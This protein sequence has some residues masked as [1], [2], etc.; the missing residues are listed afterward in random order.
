M[1]SIT[2]RRQPMTDHNHLAIAEA[3]GALASL[4][5]ALAAAGA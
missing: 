3:M 5:A 4:M 1:G 2:S